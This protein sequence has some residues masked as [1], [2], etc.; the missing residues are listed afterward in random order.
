M[1]FAWPK[2]ALEDR[3]GAAPKVGT[4][5]GMAFACEVQMSRTS[6]RVLDREQHGVN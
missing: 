6:W 2:A 4:E 3:T 1:A 5:Y